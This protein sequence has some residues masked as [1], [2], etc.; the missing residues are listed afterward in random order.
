[1][2]TVER[3]RKKLKNVES[4]VNLLKRKQEVGETYYNIIYYTYISEKS[5]KKAEDIIEK[6]AKQP[7]NIGLRRRIMQKKTVY[8]NT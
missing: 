1:M 5:Y 4:A 3:N 6:N 7:A 2:R 8:R